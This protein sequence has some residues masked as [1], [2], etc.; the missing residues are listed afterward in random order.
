MYPQFPAFKPVALDDRFVL[1]EFLWK[2]KPEASEYTFTNLFIWRWRYQVS[3]S[4]LDRWVLFSCRD[5]AGT[6]YGLQPVGADVEPEVVCEFLNWL[7]AQGGPAQTRL[8]RVEERWALAVQQTTDLV[9]EPDP[10]Q[11]DYVYRTKDLVELAGR[12]YHSK[13]NHVNRALREL[14]PKYEPLEQRHVQACLQVANKWCAAQRCCDDLGLLD[15]WDAVREAL[16]H[17]AELRTEGGVVLVDG[18]IQAFALGEL[19][20]TETAVVHVEKANP[21]FPPLFALINQQL[22]ANAWPDVPFVN[23]EQD[24]GDP[25]LRRAKQSYDP[26]HLVRKY[27]IRHR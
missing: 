21:E 17:V 11:F 12:K 19:L 7:R 15:E 8:E 23:R 16:V 9:V 5:R 3:W 14:H 24:L 6:P 18:Q 27:C 22:C 10:D 2:A 25:G 1:E 20:N 13:R 4:L 26:H